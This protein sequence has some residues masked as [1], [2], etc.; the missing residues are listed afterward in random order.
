MNNY[1]TVKK[2]VLCILDSTTYPALAPYTFVCWPIDS[3]SHIKPITS[4]RT[5]V[6]S[7]GRVIHPGIIPI[8]MALSLSEGFDTQQA[9]MGYFDDKFCNP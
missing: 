5:F 1:G 8:G 4:E 6:D 7:Q 9:L 2:L 3:I